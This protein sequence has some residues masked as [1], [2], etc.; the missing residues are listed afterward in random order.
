MLVSYR[1]SGGPKPRSDE[2]LEVQES[3]EVSL[4]R[5]VSRDRA[6]WF[7]GALG[8]EELA[9]LNKAVA[10]VAGAEVTLD[11]PGRPPYETEEI[12]T[13][14]ASLRFHPVQKLPR[15]VASLRDRLREL[16]ERFR[17]RPVA[18]IELE[19]EATFT[20]VRVSA[21][22]TR[23]VDVNW[24]GASATYDLFGK[25]EA[26]LGSGVVELVLPNGP[27]TVAPGWTREEQLAGVEFEAGRTL[28]VRLTLSMKYPDGAWRE[29]QVTAV[30]G[31]G[32]S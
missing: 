5:V 15:P 24:E 6:G 1:R 17:E 9:A 19:V 11:A 16:A 22:G 7:E 13:G 23:E 32:W 31:K 30:A 18:A 10:G 20:S 14:A 2:L 26:L 21:V 3:G 12:V 8:G 25:D 4:R 27:Q 29:A 28:Q